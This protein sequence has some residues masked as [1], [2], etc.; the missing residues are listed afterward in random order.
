MIGDCDFKI[1]PFFEKSFSKNLKQNIF[2][3][4]SFFFETSTSKASLKQTVN[5][6][7][8]LGLGKSIFIFTNL[9]WTPYCIHRVILRYDTISYSQNAL[10][11][12]TSMGQVCYYKQCIINR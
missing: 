3:F 5:V 11:L 4:F 2:L 9:H 12:S 7:L 8:G 6:A 1:C 10:N